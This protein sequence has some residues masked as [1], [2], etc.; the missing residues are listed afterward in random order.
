MK[1]KTEDREALLRK[2]EEVN[3]R[4]E[5]L[6]QGMKRLDFEGPYLKKPPS[7]FPHVPPIHF[8][9]PPPQSNDHPVQPQQD[10]PNLRSI[11]SVTHN[12][13]MDEILKMRTEYLKKGGGDPNML[14]QMRKLEIEALQFLT[15]VDSGAPVKDEEEEA[16][17]KRLQK[18][19]EQIDKEQAHTHELTKMKM[20]HE[21]QML[22]LEIMQERL[23]KESEI[24]R[25]KKEL[26]IDTVGDDLA[27]SNP[28]ER[29][30]GSSSDKT[31]RQNY[32]E[33]EGPPEQLSVTFEDL[34]SV[35]TPRY[36]PA[37]GFYVFWDFVTGIPFYALGENVQ[38]SFACF[39]GVEAK[40]GVVFLNP[41]GCSGDPASH[42]ISAFFGVWKK[43]VHIPN[44]TTFRFI[45]E[46][47]LI[48]SDGVSIAKSMGWTSISI[49]NENGLNAGLWKV[50]MYPLPID[51]VI[52]TT[53]LY[54]RKPIPGLFIDLRIADS[55][56]FHVH[57]KVSVDPNLHRKYYRQILPRNGE[58]R[59]FARPD[60][61][62]QEI[63]FEREF[64]PPSPPKVV[65]KPKPPPPKPRSPQKTTILVRIE[66]L[67][68]FVERLLPT[69]KV[70]PTVNGELISDVFQTP[71]AEPGRSDGVHGWPAGEQIATFRSLLMDSR[72]KIRVTI[73][74]ADNGVLKPGIFRNE[75]PLFARTSPDTF[76]DIALMAGSKE[77]RLD[78]VADDGVQEEVKP[79]PSVILTVFRGDDVLPPL[80]KFQ[81]RPYIPPL[82]HEA[83]HEN[84]REIDWSSKISPGDTVALFIDRARFLPQN[85]TISRIVG[86][87]FDFKFK[88]FADKTE[89]TTCVS[90]RSFIHS[91]EYFFFRQKL[92]PTATLLLKIYCIESTTFE[93]QQVG[94]A[95]F[96]LFLDASTRK[97]PTSNDPGRAIVLNEGGHQIPVHWG[98]V[99]VEALLSGDA[100]NDVPRLG[101][102][103]EEEEVVQKWM[104]R[105]LSKR[106]GVA[107][108]LIDLASICRYNQLHGLSIAVQSAQ[109][110]RHEGFGIAAIQIVQADGNAMPPIF[111]SEVD[112]NSPA[113]SP[114]WKDE[115]K[116]LQDLAWDLRTTAL[117]SV[118]SIA[119]I[120][121]KGEWELRDQ[122]WT[123][124]C[125]FREDSYADY[126]YYQ[127]PLFLG[128][129]DPKL[130]L[131]VGA[132]GWETA[133]TRAMEQK[134]IT[135][136]KSSSVF[137]KIT[138]ARRTSEMKMMTEPDSSWLPTKG[139]Q[140]FIKSR[141]TST[142]N[143]LIPHK[144]DPAEFAAQA[145]S[146][147]KSK[148]LQE[149]DRQSRRGS[150]EG[151]SRESVGT[152]V[153]PSFSKST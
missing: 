114:K 76:V 78:F 115:V 100:L 107:I 99:D 103:N 70:Q 123:G 121:R 17:A 85:V 135:L 15:K 14:S 110:L 133:T 35:S 28:E 74:F 38:L 127:L 124:F 131:E 37:R 138:D 53:Q 97:Q 109:N 54:S 22:K 65:P 13:L 2:R 147:L 57:S 50:P 29:T 152:R 27:A 105:K 11:E 94:T 122:G 19:H 119:F 129:P 80:E 77:V 48:D 145:Q 45:L 12:E 153:R 139:R 33:T 143:S 112:L 42:I 61:S 36:E 40:K 71:Q 130:L 95:V 34:S 67:R 51:F 44:R 149:I 66:S 49:F 69:V 25:L 150:E 56:A 88:P 144:F 134:R 140:Q 118:Y 1:D 81:V 63:G 86:R 79:Q 128:C 6:Q 108:P 113:K 5:A 142:L 26:E 7:T 9:A 117:V 20:E 16:E 82:P 60:M 141:R 39:D 84:R 10:G 92:P 55:M 151:N 136:T 132:L 120:V 146:V 98:N 73:K 32:R 137:I 23:M 87:I 18:E 46:L 62:D 72:V 106:P 43:F 31:I 68:G 125:P 90:F 47:S 75:V 30:K 102:P 104:E 101:A 24:R 111:F 4:L 93:L 148:V 3:K 59:E 91:P 64:L 83:W 41:A 89:I 58:E 52:T 21:R 116:N 126:G 8:P 96:P